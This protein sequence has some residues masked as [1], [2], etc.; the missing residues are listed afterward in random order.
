VSIR[1]P[2]KRRCP[3]CGRLVWASR[4]VIERHPQT[5]HMQRESGDYLCGAAGLR[6]AAE[7]PV[8]WVRD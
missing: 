1:K 3:A 8:R 5:P 4:G 7:A 6:L 2:R